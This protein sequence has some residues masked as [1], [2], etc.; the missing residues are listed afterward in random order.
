MREDTTADIVGIV[1]KV[2]CTAGGKDH[3]SPRSVKKLVT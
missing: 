2:V 3:T 1:S